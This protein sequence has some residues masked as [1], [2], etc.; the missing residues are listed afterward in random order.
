MKKS[1]ILLIKPVGKRQVYNLEMKG[2]QH[3][4]ILANGLVSKNS[5]ATAYSLL[6]YWTMYLKIKHPLEFMTAALQVEKSED[7]RR[8]YIKEA[9]RLGLAVKHPE[10]NV[11]G[12]GFV[13]DP[14]EDK[15]IRCGLQDVKGVGK[16]AVEKLVEGQPYADLEDFVKRSGANKTVLVAL[17]KVGALDKLTDNAKRV[18]ESIDQITRAKRRKHWDVAWPEVE[19]AETE[20]YTD[21]DRARFHY[22]LLALPPAIHPSIEWGE[23]VKRH[24]GKHVV[25]SPITAV[26]ETLTEPAMNNRNLCFVGV[27]TRVQWFSEDAEVGGKK[28]RRK[29]VKL[30]IEDDSDYLMVGP[31]WDQ[32]QRI[33]DKNLREKDPFLVIGSRRSDYKLRCSLLVNLREFKESVEASKALGNSPILRF[34][35]GDPDRYLLTDP[36]WMYTDAL[37]EQDFFEP[38]GCGLNRFATAVYVLNVDK[39]I[40]RKG[41]PY[42]TMTCQDWWGEIRDILVWRDGIKKCGSVLR[43]GDTLAMHVKV[44][45]KG[46]QQT[47]QFDDEGG[48]RRKR[49]QS[50]QDVLKIRATKTRQ[51]G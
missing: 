45:T 42:W 46:K 20:D 40:S 7:K 27:C 43:Q 36:L 17:A 3:N 26:E 29:M 18:V 23:W 5:H 33:G 22:E 8:A 14:T 16:K 48:G 37:N 11:S 4:Y 21:E 41:N 6:S 38:L 49:A 51:V 2:P 19:W 50:L 24:C 35:W 39:R 9:N 12:F 1:R 28:V 30:S 32:W 25:V 31:T 34:F 10:A 15:T 44:A 47:I 13:I